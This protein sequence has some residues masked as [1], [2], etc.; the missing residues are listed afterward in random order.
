MNPKKLSS[1][2]LH[3]QDSKLSVTKTSSQLLKLETSCPSRGLQQLVPSVPRQNQQ[4]MARW[5]P[6]PDQSQLSRLSGSLELGGEDLGPACPKI[7][8]LCLGQQGEWKLLNQ[9][10]L[11]LHL[12]RVLGFLNQLLAREARILFVCSDDLHGP[13]VREAARQLKQP[14]VTQGWVHGLLTNWKQVLA[15]KRV[16]ELTL[17]Y[18]SFASASKKKKYLG[19]TQLTRLP[20]LLFV[21]DPITNLAAIREAKQMNLPV[22]SFLDLESPRSESVDYWLPISCRA[23]RKIYGFFRLL[24]LHAKKEVS[25]KKDLTT[26]RA[27]L[28]A[29]ARNER[30][31]QGKLA[32]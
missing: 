18:G 14:H 5:K 21:V 17:T 29:K 12:K 31:E 15:S 3:D 30:P 6:R 10:N 25:K 23:S 22:I 7:Y 1:A 24:V 16:V 4:A 32:V 20:D 28:A 8:P 9:E 26:K 19:L 11:S 13:M 2:W 27:A